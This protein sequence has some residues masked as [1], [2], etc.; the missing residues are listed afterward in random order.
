[1]LPVCSKSLSHGNER[2]CLTRAIIHRAERRSGRQNY[3]N[4]ICRHW[5]GLLE[6]RLKEKYVGNVVPLRDSR[7][8]IWDVQLEIRD[9]HPVIRVH[10]RRTMVL[11]RNDTVD[12][13]T[14]A[15]TSLQSLSMPPPLSIGLRFFRM[16]S[17]PLCPSTR[18]VGNPALSCP[19]STSSWASPRGFRESSA[20]VMLKLGLVARPYNIIQHATQPKYITFCQIYMGK[21]LAYCQTRARHTRA[22]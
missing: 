6:G 7:L 4:A 20:Q 19:T 18:V 10:Q 2:L 22:S 3:S 11:I 13:H 14:L 16:Y 8:E 9:T 5:S 1:M 12:A 15:A 21:Q 17:V